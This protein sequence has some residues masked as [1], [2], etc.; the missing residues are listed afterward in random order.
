MI[1]YGDEVAEF[2]SQKLSCAFHH[3][4]VAI[5]V[6]QSGVVRAGA[7]LNCYIEGVDIEVTLAALP[8][9]LTKN[10]LR[11]LQSYIFDQAKCTRV[12]FT[13]SDS[14]V[15]TVLQKAGAVIEGVKRRATKDGKDAV[16]LGLLREDWRKV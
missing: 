11:A 9:S 12:S 10:L 15:V 14:H 4:Y 3:P 2:V 1:I 8:H 5:G 16:L 7:V 6:K 13:T